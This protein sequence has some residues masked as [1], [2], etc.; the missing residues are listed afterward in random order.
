MDEGCGDGVA[1][2]DSELICTRI[3][4]SED[5]ILGLI[6]ENVDFDRNVLRHWR[7]NGVKTFEGQRV[8]EQGFKGRQAEV[9]GSR[10]ASISSEICREQDFS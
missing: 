7:W 6:V 3:S 9:S 4:R 5:C 8:F 2:V 1:T 10:G